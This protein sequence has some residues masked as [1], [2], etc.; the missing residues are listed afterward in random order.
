M[1][2]LR[3][4][5]NKNFKACLILNFNAMESNNIS[6]RINLTCALKAQ[7]RKKPFDRWQLMHLVKQIVADSPIKKKEL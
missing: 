5:L 7:V 1:T 2:G 3:H 4:L 6:E